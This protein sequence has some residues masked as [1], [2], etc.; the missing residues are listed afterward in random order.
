ME[1]PNFKD[2]RASISTTETINNPTRAEIKSSRVIIQDN[3]NNE[4]KAKSDNLSLDS[5]NM[6]K[7]KSPLATKFISLTGNKELGYQKTDK[8]FKTEFSEGTKAEYYASS[9]T[10]YTPPKDLKPI[11][12]DINGIFN[13]W[14]DADETRNKIEEI[15]GQNLELYHNKTHGLSDMVEA[16]SELLNSDILGEVAKKGNNLLPKSNENKAEIQSNIEKFFSK[17]GEKIE[18]ASESEKVAAILY[19]L[20]KMGYEPRLMAH[21]QGAAITSE[22]LN[23]LRERLLTENNNLAETE[24]SMANISV[25]TIGGFANRADFPDEVSLI[26]IENLLSNKE[27]RDPVSHIS[28]A[29]TGILGMGNEQ[30]DYE[31]RVVT[32]LIAQDPNRSTLEK[33][34]LKNTINASIELTKATKS[35][36]RFAISAINTN[37]SIV[38]TIINSLR[39]GGKV[40]EEHGARTGYLDKKF[41]EDI[42]YNFFNRK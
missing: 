19:S 42:T 26:K 30:L 25:L 22:A 21:S 27:G 7:S 6:P 18:N 23:I 10:N 28:N 33:V 17:S 11:N 36:G 5:A 37:N 38:P 20:T 34:F 31:K 40:L 32:T 4:L 2:V 16:V 39:N 8:P 24:K 41:V 12:I 9:V 14:K 13:S 15:S 29:N 3:S 1:L 35:V